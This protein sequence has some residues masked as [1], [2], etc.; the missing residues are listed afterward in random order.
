[1]EIN[2]RFCF[3]LP[4]DDPTENLTVS[5]G[6][7]AAILNLLLRDVRYLIF[8]EPTAVLTPSE[9]QNLFE[10]FTTLRN[11]GRG[12]VLISHK[13]E[14]TLQIAGRVTVLRQGKTRVSCKTGDLSSGALYEHIFGDVSASSAVGT[15]AAS[16]TSQGEPSGTAQVPS[17]A[18]GAPDLPALL[19]RDFNVN[20][21]G[22][23]LIRGINL[24]LPR[25]KIMGIA[26]VRDSGLETL[27]LA[28]TGFLPSSGTLRINGIDL[29]GGGRNA[30]RH[31]AERGAGRATKR[32]GRN[33][34]FSVAKKIRAF[35]AAGG[36]YL[37]TRNEGTTLPVRDLLIIHSHRRLQK[38]GVLNQKK[39][40]SW[41]EPVLTAAGISFN[42]K[43]ARTFADGT[44]SA[45]ALPASSFSGG[46][47]QRLLLAR[48][49]AEQGVLLVLSDPGRGLDREY[50]KILAALLREK[51][52]E[53]KS[54]LI[55]STDVE[56]LIALS[57]TVAVLRNGV[58]SQVIELSST[59]SR[60]HAP[61]LIREA[62]VG[63][64]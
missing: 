46:Q 12:I 1:M 35:R 27:E 5:Q 42:D 48:E 59:D 61:D 18:F 54:A 9:T 64:T 16:A 4:L 63:R 6:Q 26:G 19:L 47:L 62:M 44:F 56:E 33:I 41:I 14:E 39:I 24:D 57:D 13:L 17:T 8:D 15:N 20:V 49:M 50:R 38:R 52:A 25:G 22:R 60:L 23:P 11:E 7:K 43:A 45:G 58:F 32:S 28:L 29:S 36:T 53:G 55:F 51:T 40:N 34:V 37:D 21:P 10:L 30:E 2:R 3:D 31:T